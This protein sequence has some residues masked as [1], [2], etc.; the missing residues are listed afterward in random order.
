MQDSTAP[1]DD[2]TGRFRD[3]NG[4]AAQSFALDSAAL[5]P[6]LRDQA[7]GWGRSLDDAES[8]STHSSDSTWTKFLQQYSFDY[9]PDYCL[10]VRKR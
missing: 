4:G 2:V 6:Y 5:D 3:G 10:K 8:V 1:Q 7:R 9:K